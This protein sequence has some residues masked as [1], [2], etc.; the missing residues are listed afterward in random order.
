M[1]Y[2]NDLKLRIEPVYDGRGTSV[3]QYKVVDEKGTLQMQGSYSD[4][5][6]YI[7]GSGDRFTDKDTDHAITGN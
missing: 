1:S 6:H 5:Y 2:T 3:T 4:C 7:Y